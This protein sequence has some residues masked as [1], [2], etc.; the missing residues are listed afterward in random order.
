MTLQEQIKPNEG[1]PAMLRR[2]YK[3]GFIEQQVTFSSI[4][5]ER[6]GEKSHNDSCF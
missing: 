4:I 1:I 2:I 5:G 3:G 6:L